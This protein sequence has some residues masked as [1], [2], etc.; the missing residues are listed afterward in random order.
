MVGLCARPDSCGLLLSARVPFT[1]F[2]PWH[3]YVC[4][5]V[6]HSW[7][8]FPSPSDRC[9]WCDQ[10][11][12][13]IGNFSAFALRV[14]KWAIS[15][16]EKYNLSV[17]GLK[18]STALLQKNKPSGKETHAVMT[19]MRKE[20]RSCSLAIFDSVSIRTISGCFDRQLEIGVITEIASLMVWI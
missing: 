5:G 18:G 14:F 3:T 20:K 11:G 15:V 16:S 17:T 9:T 4:V 2:F 7:L 1:K 13:Q 19:R 12:K 8:T 6:T 10:I